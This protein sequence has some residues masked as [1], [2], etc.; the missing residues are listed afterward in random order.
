MNRSPLAL[1]IAATL[2]S[3]LQLSAQEGPKED[4][5]LIFDKIEEDQRAVPV[6]PAPP[7]AESA[8]AFQRPLP[9][10]SNGSLRTILLDVP[11]KS[12][13]T[14]RVSVLSASA[15]QRGSEAGPSVQ[16][17]DATVSLQSSLD[18]ATASLLAANPKF[19][20]GVTLTV[21][22]EG[23]Y[24][25]HEHDSAAAATAIILESIG[26]GRAIDPEA[27]LLGGVDDK[28]R[29]TAVQRLATRLRTLEGVVPPVIGVPM[30]SEVEV[31]DLALMNELD[32]LAKLQIISLVT[33]DDARAITAK[34]RPEK[35]AKAFTLFEG[36][37]LV[38]ASTPITMLLKNPKFLQRLK[39]ITELMPNHLSARLLL[40]AAS[41]KVPGRITFA[42]SRQA[43]LKAIKPFVN[44]TSTNRPG[45][46]IQTVATEGGNVLL[47]MQPK[48]HPAA[49]RYLVAMKA[50]LRSVSN[51]FDIP[52]TPQHVIMRNRAVTE[53]NKLLASVQVEKEKLDKAEGTLQ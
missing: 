52:N 42:T 27:A 49:E 45:K 21:K 33:L 25:S 5:F 50:Y 32:V 51:F 39:E 26:T 23:G 44:V 17:E 37:R 48:I 28:G 9:G 36:V 16:F 12:F 40:Q 7:P 34:D 19:P 43:I 18:K 46:E 6:K 29:I 31:R 11:D 41:N 1:I 2:A 35:V 38:A 22:A 13:A 47:R 24:G 14:G 53:I 30:V 4:D 20:D 15:T 8:P 10:S 3:C